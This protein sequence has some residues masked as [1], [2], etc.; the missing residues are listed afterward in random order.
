M[1]FVPLLLAVRSGLRTVVVPPQCTNGAAGGV[2][3][4]APL[5]IVTPLF[6]RRPQAAIAAE[7][8]K[9]KD[10]LAAVEAEAK[11]KFE[12]AAK[13]ASERYAAECEKV[14]QKLMAEKRQQDQLGDA[15]EKQVHAA[16]SKLAGLYKERQQARL[17][18][19]GF[20]WAL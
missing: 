2:R 5:L 20:V 4:R 1:R 14:L 18:K 10:A 12:A 11:A 7:R 6:L 15:L 9:T 3:R 19:A 17:R 8:Q 13:V 16:E